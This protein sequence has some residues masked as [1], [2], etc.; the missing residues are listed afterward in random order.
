MLIRNQTDSLTETNTRLNKIEVHKELLK[1]SE[2]AGGVTV[3]GNKIINT[4]SLMD[5]Y[6]Q[7]LKQNQKYR[8]VAKCAYRWLYLTRRRLR[9]KGKSSGH[10]LM[11]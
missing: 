7:Q 8:L 9:L 11:A 3:T 6:S 10:I 1:R 2:G 4:L 5:V